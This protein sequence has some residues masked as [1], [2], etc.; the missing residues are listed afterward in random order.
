VTDRD[1][2]VEGVNAA[3]DRGPQARR[4]CREGDTQSRT[5][6]ARREMGGVGWGGGGEM[7]FARA[8]ARTHGYARTWQADAFIY[9]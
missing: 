7:R 9:S 2:R 6:R 3:L 5:Q 1:R 4:R 8:H